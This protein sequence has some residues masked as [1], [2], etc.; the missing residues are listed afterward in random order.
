M[1]ETKK[2]ETAGDDK[3]TG[4]I[5]SQGELKSQPSV[6]PLLWSRF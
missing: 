1:A 3:W 6:A 2:A 4:D 5:H